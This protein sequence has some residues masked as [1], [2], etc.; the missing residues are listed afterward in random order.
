MR[1]QHWVG[2]FLL[3]ISV[4]LLHA[5]TTSHSLSVNSLSQNS[6][7]LLEE[8][9][10]L[11]DAFWDDHAKLLTNPRPMVVRSGVYLVR[12]S[13]WYALALLLRDA[14]GD[15]KRADEILSTVLDQQYLIPEAPWY[16]TFRRSPEEPTPAAD[17]QMWDA[18]DP[19]WREF[20]GSTFALILIEFPDRISSSLARRMYDAIDRAVEGEIEQKRLTPNYTNVALMYGFLWSFAA[21]HNHR[22][23]WQRQAEDWSTEIYRLFRRHDAFDEYNSPTYYGVDLYA[24]A[25]WRSYGATAHMRAMGRR[26]EARLWREI[27]DF[28]HP[29]LRNLCGPYDRAYGIDMENYVSLLGVWMRSFESAKAAPL[30]PI[31]A[32]ADHVAD[33]WFAPNIVIL[34]TRVPHDA[35]MKLAH[36][37]GD[38]GLRKRLDGQ[39]IVTAWI[40]QDLMFGGEAT[41]KTRGADPAKQFVPATIHWRTPAGALSWISIVDSSALDAAADS[42]GLAIS[43]NG[44]VRFHIEPAE[45]SNTSIGATMWTLSGLNVQVMSDARQFRVEP[46]GF[47]LDVIYFG[48]TAIRLTIQL[49][50]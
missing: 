48:V 45:T 4:S 15:R 21:E 17:G 16:G 8:S 5:Q 31:S 32:T 12:E 10:R 23:D 18:Y 36:F 47:G 30:P 38:H 26:I 3:L 1:K 46:S 9:M 2:L 19:N 44:T 6:R 22:R 34:G 29:G 42:Q 39:R 40:G 20:I 14:P 24:L 43:T 37:Q 49:R 7:E 28:Y 11:E 35:S 50:Q 41:G 13:S 33:M 27:A 25:L